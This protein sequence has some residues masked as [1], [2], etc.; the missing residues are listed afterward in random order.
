MP[1]YNEERFYIS[2][3]KEK[4]TSSES[5]SKDDL[6]EL[7]EK[8]EELLEMNVVTIKIIDKLMIN[9]D[10]LKREIVEKR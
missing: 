2:R 6:L 10:K 4:V 8:Y 5:I 3:V 1:L 7:T 9:Y